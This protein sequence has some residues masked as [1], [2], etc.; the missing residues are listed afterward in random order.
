M[1]NCD[2]DSDLGNEDSIGLLDVVEHL[3]DRLL[4]GP[5]THFLKQSHLGVLS[6]DLLS[7]QS[8]NSTLIS[9]LIFENVYFYLRCPILY[10][11]VCIALVL[12]LSVVVLKFVAGVKFK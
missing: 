2:D 12:Q 8:S 11:Y 4:V 9:F 1:S 6:I 7:L 3:Q 5:F 10:I